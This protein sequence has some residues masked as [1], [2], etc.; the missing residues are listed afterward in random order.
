MCDHELADALL[1][2]DDLEE[3]GVIHGGWDRVTCWTHQRWYRHCRQDPRHT[4]PLSD[5]IRPER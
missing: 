5:H 3:R 1:I 2:E 4:R